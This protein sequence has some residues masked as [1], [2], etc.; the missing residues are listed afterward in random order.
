MVY[1]SLI[2]KDTDEIYEEVKEYIK[3]YKFRVIRRGILIDVDMVF[4][5]GEYTLYL[6]AASGGDDR[7]PGAMLFDDRDIEEVLKVAR[8]M[9][10]A[11]N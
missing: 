3:N 11:L 10:G 7:Q 2:V 9:A 8:Q 1:R 6:E 5:E 4:G